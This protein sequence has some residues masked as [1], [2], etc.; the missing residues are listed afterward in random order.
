MSLRSKPSVI[1]VLKYTNIFFEMSSSRIYL[2]VVLIN[3]PMS[4]KH[5]NSFKASNVH[6]NK[7]I[8]GKSKLDFRVESSPKRNQFSNQF[9]ELEFG[10]MAR[11]HSGP[12]KNSLTVKVMSHSYV[13]CWSEDEPMMDL[14]LF[15]TSSVKN[16]QKFNWAISSDSCRIQRTLL[17]DRIMNWFFALIIY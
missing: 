3:V 15:H 8:P 17:S 1:L 12:T 11:K 10:M 2:M 6:F 16:S 14:L 4:K 5:T 13:T 9:S 7:F